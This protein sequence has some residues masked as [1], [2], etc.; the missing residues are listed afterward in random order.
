MELAQKVEIIYGIIDRQLGVNHYGGAQLK[1]TVYG[2][3]DLLNREGFRERDLIR[4]A[5]VYIRE[6]RTM[7]AYR[8][9]AS[10]P[11][12]T[13]SNRLEI[14]EINIVRVEV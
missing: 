13:Y 14:E 5:N 1:H 9:V 2:V 7:R 8:G 10:Y 4:L 6:Y 11:I 3:F 12:W